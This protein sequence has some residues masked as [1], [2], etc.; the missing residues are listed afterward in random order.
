MKISVAMATYNGERF[1][2]EQLDSVAAQRRL[3][4]ELVVCDDGSSDRT[5]DVVREFAGAAP[6]PVRVYRNDTNLGYADN[7]L[8][9]AGVCR[10]D[11]IAFCDQDDIWLP[12][13]LS[14]VERYFQVPGREVV[15][16]VH[17]ALVVE[18]SL[19]PSGVRYPNIAKSRV[20]RGSDLPSLWFAGGLTMV[21]RSDLIARC[22]PRDR[23]PGH[24]PEGE[25]LAHDAWI[26]WLACILG[27]VALLQDSLVLYRRHSAST[28]RNLTGNVGEI[29]ASR[30][31]L[32][33]VRARFVERG[34][35]TYRRMSDAMLSHAKAFR[36]IACEQEEGPWRHKLLEAEHRYR[37][38]AMWLAERSAACDG[39]GL[40]SR[41]YHLCRAIKMGGYINY[42]GAERRLGLRALAKDLVVSFIG[43]HRLAQVL[44]KEVIN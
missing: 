32:R 35:S 2:R 39:A 15:L 5:L 8:K 27:D 23:G 9:A 24:G 28:T 18:E 40:V 36:R 37:C 16:V 21:F 33:S 38:Q 34:G 13:K 31:A 19:L 7:F 26:S 6:F 10:G 4:D 43:G 42:Y 30:Q 3:P 41:I 20:C 25:P 14:T 44:G 17:N 29:R 11:W 12:D 1:I 22:S